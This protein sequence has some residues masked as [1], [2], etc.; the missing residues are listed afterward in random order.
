VD[1]PLP[2]PADVAVMP[3]GAG[4]ALTGAGQQPMS[5]AAL[6]APGT[7][8]ATAPSGG[9]SGALARLAM[10]GSADPTSSEV[11]ARQQREEEERKAAE[12]AKASR[13]RRTLA[14]FSRNT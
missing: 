10:P 3:A 7:A 13:V 11:R 6:A 8:A 9:V 12:L 2:S 5:P 1:R 4:A 14:F